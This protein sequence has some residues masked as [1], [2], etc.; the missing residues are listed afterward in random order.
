VR[1]VLRVLGVFKI[2]VWSS[3]R[4]LPVESASD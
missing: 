2:F 4:G 1:S 3:H